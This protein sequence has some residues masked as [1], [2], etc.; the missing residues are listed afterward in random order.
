MGRNR[1][2]STACRQLSQNSTQTSATAH[3]NQVQS[4]TVPSRQPVQADTSRQ[5]RAQ[6]DRLTLPPNYTLLILQIFTVEAWP[7]SP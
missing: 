1:L 5:P 3:L 2:L 4:M 6:S 7:V